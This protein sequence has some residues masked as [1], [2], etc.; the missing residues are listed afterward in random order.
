MQEQLVSQASLVKVAIIG[1]RSSPLA[2][3]LIITSRLEII[4]G[5][6][7]SLRDSR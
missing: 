3:G 7:M 5:N 6:N 4:E 2:L 1:N